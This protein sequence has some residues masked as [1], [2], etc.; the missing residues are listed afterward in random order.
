MH[1][2][3]L[4]ELNSRQAGA[5][6]PG[7]PDIAGLRR[8][9]HRYADAGWPVFPCQPGGKIPASRH[10]HLDATTSSARIDR[11]WTRAPDANIGI[12]TGS[13]GPDVLDIDVRPGRNGF[14]ALR[15]A[16]RG[17]LVPSPIA[18]V[19]SPSG[20]AHLYFPGTEQRCGALPACALDFR[21]AGGSIIA[22]PSWSAAHRRRYQLV[23]SAHSGTPVNWAAIRDLLSPARPQPASRWSARR[24]DAEL[25]AR[26]TSWLETRPEGNRNYPLFWAARLIT[27]AGLM[28]ARVREELIAASLRS[29][30]RGGESEARRT[31]ASGEK[32]GIAMLVAPVSGTNRE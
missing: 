27:A 21:A 30:L 17:G 19:R 11:W 13:P 25:V 6:D 24:G 8:A 18:V 32:A 14:T 23:S 9:A 5:P 12:A 29:G 22:P 31:L 15:Q 26:L 1:P 20:G 16:S 7:R 4:D 28:D 3:D 10:G 2:Q